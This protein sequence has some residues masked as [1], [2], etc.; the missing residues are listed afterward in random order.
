VPHWDKYKHQLWYAGELLIAFDRVSPCQELIPA[1]FEEQHWVSC[2]DD[3]LPGGDGNRKERLHNTIVRLNAHMRIKL[4][5]FRR[6]GTGRRILWEPIQVAGWRTA[7]GRHCRRRRDRNPSSEIDVNR[8]EPHAG[9]AD[10]RDLD[11]D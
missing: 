9:L 8:N 2:I 4:M 11:Q 7:F 6:D 10:Q 5:R 3:P 1:A